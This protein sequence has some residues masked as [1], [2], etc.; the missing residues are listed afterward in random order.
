MPRIEQNEVTSDRAQRYDRGESQGQGTAVLD[1]RH[2]AW[3][4]F[5]ALR[6][7][8]ETFQH[9]QSCLL[10]FLPGSYGCL[11]LAFRPLARLTPLQA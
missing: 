7:K 6:G 3:C 1:F 9:R 4:V 2:R 5:G 8:L 11:S 10:S